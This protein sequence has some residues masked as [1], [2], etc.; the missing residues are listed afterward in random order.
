MRRYAETFFRYWYLALIPLIMLSVVGVPVARGSAGTFTTTANLEVAS[1]VS[2]QI[3]NYNTYITPAQNEATVLSELLGSPSF[4][5]GIIYSADA[6]A[7]RNWAT[8]KAHGVNAVQYMVSDVA[9]N[10]VLTPHNHLVVVS[11]TGQD[12]NLAVGAVAGASI[13]QAFVSTVIDRASAQSNAQLAASIAAY[14]SQLASARRHQGASYTQLRAWMQRHGYAGPDP[15]AGTQAAGITDPQYDALYQQYLFDKSNSDNIQ[16]KLLTA[17]VTQQTNVQLGGA[18]LSE[19]DPPS[20]SGSSATRKELTTLLIFA[21][22]GLA[23]SIVFL[24]ARTALDRGLRYADEVAEL[25][26]VPTLAVVPYSRRRPAGSGA[27]PLT[28]GRAGAAA[29]SGRLADAK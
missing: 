4:D 19:L 27:R 11:Y 16:N 13:V 5:E 17:Q 7:Y 15:S 25:L 26:R 6:A 2:S 10:L 14:K 21:G 18:T 28:A 8:I 12:R 20:T 29:T 9:R 3:D 22:V 1:S 23:L 24:V